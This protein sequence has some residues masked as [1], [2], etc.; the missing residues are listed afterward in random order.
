MK[1]ESLN[2][3]WFI[4][5][6]GTIVKHLYND[7]I[8]SAI[9]KEGEKS[10]LMETPIKQSINFLNS[11]PLNDIIVLTTARDSK[12]KD[13]TLKMLQHYNIKYDR[14]LFDLCSGPRYVINDTKPVGVVGNKKPIQTAFAINV[15]RDVGINS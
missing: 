6:D 9:E 2:K 7:S 3:T 11:I 8:D 14:I 13:H 15:E 10:H 12:H 1:E 5:I 4:D